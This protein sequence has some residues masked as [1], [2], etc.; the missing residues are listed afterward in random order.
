MKLSSFKIF[1]LSLL[2]FS[3][4]TKCPVYVRFN[5]VTLPSLYDLL[6]VGELQWGGTRLHPRRYS[7]DGERWALE[8]GDEAHNLNWHKTSNKERTFH[9]S[10]GSLHFNGQ[11]LLRHDLTLTKK[12]N[13]VEPI[14]SQIPKGTQGSPEPQV[15][16]AYSVVTQSQDPLP[17]KISKQGVE[18][19]HQSFTSITPYA[20]NCAV[21]ACVTACA[22]AGIAIKYWPFSR[23]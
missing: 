1:I 15:P 12:G 18:Y 2:F 10:R 14:Q 20:K 21:G 4:H 6:D 11:P 22:L 7:I 8:K 13:F 5:P 17:L 16:N 23:K 19:S 9:F 3:H